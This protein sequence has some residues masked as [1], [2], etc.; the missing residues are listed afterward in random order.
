M[1]V[2]VVLEHRFARTPEGCV[3]TAGPFGYS[4]WK[5]YL[6]VFE[7]VRVVARVREVACRPPGWLRADGAAVGFEPV[8]CYVGPWQYLRCRR[9]VKRA[10]RGSICGADA[11]VLRVPSQL[12]CCLEAPLLRS[13]RPYGVEVVGDPYDA[14]SPGSTRH[15]L[16][17]FFRRWF[18]Q[19]L[20]VQCSHSSVSAYVTEQALQRRYPP[21]PKRFT[22]AYSSVEL[23]VESFVS[24]ARG[25]RRSGSAFR[26]I[27][28]AGLDH[29]YK[30]PDILIAALA[31]CVQK[32]LD[33]HLAVVGDG[34]YRARLEARVAA[35]GLAERVSFRGLLADRDALRSQLDQAD[36][37]VLPSRQEGL[38]RALLE[39]MARALPAIGSTAG[40]IPELLPP[41]DLVAPADIGALAA[42]IAEVLT[43]PARLQAMSARNLAKARGYRDQLTSRHRERYLLELRRLT[44]DWLARSGPVSLWA[45]SR[46]APESGGSP[47]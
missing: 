15:P 24:A 18:R 4:F 6:G 45:R 40:G 28:V 42:K 43:D 22:T 14:L 23:P 25:E 37:F 27:T 31:A 10:V 1:T 32:G 11:L 20:L 8:S 35:L 34:R 38:P 2:V 29:L 9:A 33:L 30:A 17:A 26:L 5:R 41:E 39:A 12:A 13:G 7:Q 46:L 16:R 21:H 44:E 36:L 47:S 19:R 3:W